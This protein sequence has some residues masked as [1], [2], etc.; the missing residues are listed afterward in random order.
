MGMPLKRQDYF[1]HHVAGRGYVVIDATSGWVTEPTPFRVQADRARDE[2]QRKADAKAKRG[3]RDCLG[4]GKPF[5][6]EGVHNRMCGGCRHRAQDETAA[7]F[8]FGTIHGRK[9]A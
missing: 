5:D 4:C 6:S 8:A 9:R 7:P 2:Y 3:P 1:T